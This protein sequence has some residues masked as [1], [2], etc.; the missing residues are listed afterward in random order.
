M[1]TLGYIGVGQELFARFVVKSPEDL[2]M[3][4]I[5]MVDG[6]LFAKNV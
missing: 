5:R 1:T 6:L 3:K 2:I 4:S